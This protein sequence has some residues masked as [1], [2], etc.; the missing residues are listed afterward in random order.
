MTDEK[1]AV[2]TVGSFVIGGE[3]GVSLAKE[4]M[5]IVATARRINEGKKNRASGL[6]TLTRQV[7]VYS[8]NELKYIVPLI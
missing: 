3:A 6:N 7:I 2:V 5:K 4:R 8:T 1:A